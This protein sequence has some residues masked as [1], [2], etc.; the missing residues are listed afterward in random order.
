MRREKLFELADLDE[1]KEGLPGFKIALHI[2]ELKT[3]KYIENKNFDNL[4]GF[5]LK[6]LGNQVLLSINNHE[7]FLIFRQEM[8]RLLLNYLASIAALKDISRNIKNKLNEKIRIQYDEQIKVMTL[9]YT[10]DFLQ[11]L[12]NYTLHKKLPLFSVKFSAY[13]KNIFDEKMEIKQVLYLKKNELLKWKKWSKNSR[14]FI[15]SHEKDELDLSEIINN[16]HI[17][18]EGFTNYFIYTIREEYKIELT[19]LETINKRMS[20]LFKELKNIKRD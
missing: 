1:K 14:N 20:D 19:E 13:R 8:F 6:N 10:I 11:N 16:Y 3:S 7:D 5:I 2:S 15:K 18:V 17:H 12:R 9:D 4:N